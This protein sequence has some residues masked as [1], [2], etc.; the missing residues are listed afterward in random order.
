[1]QKELNLYEV[2]YLVKSTFTEEE[3]SKKIN[4]YK[5]LILN[6]GS[7]VMLENRG[8]RQLSYQIQGL[9]TANYIQMLCVG[10]G[11]LIQKL[12][13]ALARDETVLRYITTKLN[14]P[15]EI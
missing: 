11:K 15:L 1:M 13:S 8:K 4:F 6:A 12:D 14:E 7:Q 9:E 10:N 5:E 2:L 3:L